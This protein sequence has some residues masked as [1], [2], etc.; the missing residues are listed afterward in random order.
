ML[1]ETF[2]FFFSV[3]GK[4]KAMVNSVHNPRPQYDSKI[5]ERDKK[6]VEYYAGDYYLTKL[7]YSSF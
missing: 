7:I 3:M 4:K 2:F 1:V 6:N 5:Q